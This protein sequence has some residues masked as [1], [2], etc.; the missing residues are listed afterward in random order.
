MKASTSLSPRSFTTKSSPRIDRAQIDRIHR[1]YGAHLIRMLC[2]RND[3]TN[4]KENRYP[5]RVMITACHLLQTFLSVE[6]GHINNDNYM[7]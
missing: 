4:N 3:S 5:A 2:R 7:E 6:M 1:S